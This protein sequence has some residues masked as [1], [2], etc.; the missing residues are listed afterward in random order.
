[1]AQ[2]T[3]TVQN[4]AHE[5]RT[6]KIVAMAGAADSS[7]VADVASAMSGILDEVAN[8][9]D[10]IIDGGELEYVNSTWIG[11]LTD[12]YRRLDEKNGRIILANLRPNVHDTLTVVGLL[13]LIP[14]YAT[15]AEAKVAL[16]EKVIAAS[17]P[18]V[19]LTA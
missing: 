10:I 13:N 6:I 12:W 11:H 2:L 17:E 16:T 4:Y 7:N 18:R 9:L 14:T 19:A 8:D 5:T 3:I 15:V 1:M